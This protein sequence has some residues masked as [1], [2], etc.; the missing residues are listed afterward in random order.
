MLGGSSLAFNLRNYPLVWEGTWSQYHSDMPFF[1]ALATSLS[2]FGPTDSIFLPGAEV[3]YHWLSYA[4]A[5]QVTEAAGAEP[6]VVLT[7]VLPFVAIL[8]CSLIVIAWARRVSSVSWVPTLAAVMLLTGGFLGAANGGVLNFDSPSQS[9]SVMWLLAFSV[10]L[11]EFLG[12]SARRTGRRRV[13]LLVWL[14]VLAFCVMGGKVSAALPALAGVGL[15]AM[16]GLIRRPEWRGRALLALAV[17][18]AA[19]GA[20]FV[21]LLA[22]S[23][24]GGGLTLG[25]LVDRA[26]SQQGLNPLNDPNSVVFGTAI[27]L[28]A[29]AVRWA[30]L[31]WLAGSRASRWEPATV[32]GVGLA[33][34]SLLAV[35]AFNSFNEIWFSVAASGPLAVLTAVGAG[36][37]SRYLAHGEPRR[38]NRQVVGALVAALVVYGV[39]WALWATGASG[40]NVWVSTWRWAGP[41]FG[42]V[43]ALLLGWVIAR[44]APRGRRIASVLA[45]TAVILVFATAP[46]RLLG[47][48]TGQVGIQQAGLKNEWF[49]VGTAVLVRERDV[50][51]VGDWTDGMMAGASWL[52]TN[53]GRDD[54]L[55]TNLTFGPFVPGVTGMRTYVS[56]LQYQAP[57]GRPGDSQRLLAR[58]GQVWDF[59]DGPSSGTVAPLCAEDVRWVWVD[60]T[61]TERRD[62]APYASIAFANED[63]LI[64]RMDPDA[65]Q[66]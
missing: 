21:L 62:W 60:P 55:A 31:A 50:K 61:L 8:A 16:V 25:S 12:E 33:V 18:V 36:E 38:G 4:W 53:A 59:I 26:S 39:V 20:A 2:R 54:L 28:V 5:G 29:I 10:V 45:A 15:V 1:E 43:L 46:G 63:V 42:V 24:G 6:F 9:M 52:R 14:G 40:G 57:Y 58:E 3:R 65:C 23:A 7:R 13:W 47:V 22:G 64:L 66:S 37:A 35:V 32:F 19:A 51:V 56:G 17:V 30:G 27:L 41:L 44:G 34:S 11:L 48:G 49:S